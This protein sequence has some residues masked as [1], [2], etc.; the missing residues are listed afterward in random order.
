[1]K[2]YFRRTVLKG[3]TNPTDSGGGGVQTFYISPS[4][5]YPY[6]YDHPDGTGHQVSPFDSVWFCG[7][8]YVGGGVGT[9]QK[10][11]SVIDAYDRFHFIRHPSSRGGG[12]NTKP[13]IVSSLRELI[14]A[15]GVS[16]ERRKNP[17]QRRRM[18]L[19]R[20][21]LPGSDRDAKAV[22]DGAGGD[23]L[24]ARSTSNKKRKLGIS[25]RGGD[26]IEHRRR[27]RGYDTK[28]KIKHSSW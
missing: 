2:E 3:G 18:R 24:D 26:N 11:Q 28:K 12:C 16:G 8:A 22:S 4:P 1:M 17:R 7:L 13:R 21:A 19:L 6:E 9:A 23:T 27:G 5:G 10:N 20:A 14:S 25:T 15:G